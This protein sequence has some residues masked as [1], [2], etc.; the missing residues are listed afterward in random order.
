MKLSIKK[1]WLVAVSFIGGFVTCALFVSTRPPSAPSAHPVWV[2]NITPLSPT[3]A[4]P[5]WSIQF[6]LPEDPA[7]KV[8]SSPSMGG[9]RSLPWAEPR[10]NVD[11]ID[12]RPA[13]DISA[14]K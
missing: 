6:E 2:Q 12:M 10:P 11:L 8:R 5:R 1:V 7:R 13:N 4:V 3:P 14:G 9:Q